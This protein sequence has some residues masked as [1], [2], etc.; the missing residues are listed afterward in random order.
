MLYSSHRS[1]SKCDQPAGVAAWTVLA[2]FFNGYIDTA[3]A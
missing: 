2:K 3:A 1:C